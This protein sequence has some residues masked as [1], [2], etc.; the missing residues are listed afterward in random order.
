MSIYTP[1]F[2]IIQD[3]RNGM[4]YAGSRWKQGCNPNEL[5]KPDGYTTSS[6]RVN[7]IIYE[8]G[9]DIFIVRKIK[10]FST[11]TEAEMY[12]RR[13]LSKV[14]AANNELFLNGHNGN[15]LMTYGTEKYYSYM[16]DTYGVKHAS[17]SAELVARRSQSNLL[18]YGCKNVYAA[19][20]IKDVI[21]Q[22]N[23]ERY[24]VEHPSY[25]KELLKKK[26]R[27]NYEKY[28]VESTLDLP[29]VRER[30]IENCW[31][32]TTREK[33]RNTNLE[34]Y[35]HELASSSDILIEKMLNTRKTLSDRPVVK[36]LREYTRYFN[37]KL[38]EGWY[39]L[40]DEKLQAILDNMETD[41]GEYSY[42]ELSNM[43]PEKKY[44]S[45]IAK[46]QSR[47]VVKEIWKYKKKYGRKIAIG[48]V[49]DRK[50]EDHLYKVLSELQKQYGIIQ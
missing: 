3:T 8:H 30:A 1:Y 2:Y 44:S 36:L 48:R 38:G 17:Q 27:N 31:T 32:D 46:L 11:N 19:D 6:N 49:W 43:I 45:S 16:L 29:G 14:D 41:Y 24:G 34:K 39:Q 7:K 10:L 4:Y 12:E 5:L 25:S 21:K 26:A 37:I 40:S 42:D 33:R 13:F 20:E 22:T 9:P 50:S 15:N 35:G 47:G 28:G 18:K 23:I